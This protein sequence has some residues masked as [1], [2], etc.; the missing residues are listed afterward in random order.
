M[1]LREVTENTTR[2]PWERARLKALRNIIRGAITL[3]RDLRILDVG[4]GDGF[5]INNLFDGI[6]VKNIDGVDLNLSIKQIEELS[7]PT[8]NISY[9]NTFD[10]IR[11]HRFDLILLLDVVEHVEDDNSFLCNIVGNHLDDDGYL[12]LTAPAYQFLFS[13]HDTFLGHYRRYT[14]KDLIGLSDSVGLKMIDCGYLFFSL[15]PLRFAFLCYE[16]LFAA[17][18]IENRGIGAWKYG[19]I[20]TKTIELILTTENNISIALS[21]FGIKVPGLTV[22]ALCRK[23]QL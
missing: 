5:V 17:E 23:P 9:H 21:R 1:D 22:W 10:N 12:M 2:H 7:S 15:I 11:D 19:S 20:I 3:N 13:S 4:C 16:R 8:K 14:L 6:S 18:G